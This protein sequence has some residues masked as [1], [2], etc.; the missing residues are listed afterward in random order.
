MVL[1]PVGSQP[2]GVYWRRRLVL[3]AVVAIVLI[4]LVRACNGGD[5]GSGPGPRASSTT[6]SAPPTASCA[7]RQL[8][9][10]VLPSAS[11]VVAG[12]GTTFKARVTSTEA[13]PCQLLLPPAKEVWTIASDTATVWT[14]AGC[15]AAGGGLEQVLQ[16]GGHTTIR[17][18]WDG[19]A[20]APNCGEGPAVPAGSYHVTLRLG[21]ATSAP[22]SLSVTT[23]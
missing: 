22:V 16:P 9:L 7:V 11:S 14:D 15:E 8:G 6:T 4:V 17:L 13:Q 20:S 21:K 18:T 12:H 1:R 10:A 19:L 3:L 2:A 5:G 23:G